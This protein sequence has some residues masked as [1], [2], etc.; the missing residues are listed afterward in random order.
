MPR[1]AASKVALHRLHI[2]RTLVLTTLFVTKDFAVKSHFKELP[3]LVMDPSKAS[4]TDT[5]DQ[6]FYESYILCL[7]LN[8]L[9]EAILTNK[10][11]VYF[12]E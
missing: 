10:Q 1:N 3:T 5:F 7:C 2:K 4:I 12:P 6:F 11:N 9:A 8:R